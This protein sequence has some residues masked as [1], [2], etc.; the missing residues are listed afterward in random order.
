[1]FAANEKMTSVA[2]A[3]PPPAASCPFPVVTA[4]PTTTNSAGAGPDSVCPARLAVP[5]N[6][7][8]LSPPPRRRLFRFIQLTPDTTPLHF[9]FYLLASLLTI[10]FF[11][12]INSSQTFVLSL[13]LGVPAKEL[14]SSVVWFAADARANLLAD[15]RLL[16]A[17]RLPFVSDPRTDAHRQH[18]R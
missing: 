1:M 5:E 4:S 12:F 11:V 3:A 7:A 17:H 10:A 15:L 14:G 18:V 13:L 8:D 9:L 2:G 16:L 6:A